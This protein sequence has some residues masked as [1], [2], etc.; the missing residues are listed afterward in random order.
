LTDTLEHTQHFFI[1][2][3]IYFHRKVILELHV[4]EMHVHYIVY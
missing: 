1:T 4:L 3:Y 2:V